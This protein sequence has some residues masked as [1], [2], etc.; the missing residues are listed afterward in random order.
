MCSETTLFAKPSAPKKRDPDVDMGGALI[1]LVAYGAQDVILTGSP[2]ITFFKQIYRRHTNFACESVKCTFSG[3]PSF[4]NKVTI[5]IPRNG[6]LLSKTYIRVA[7]SA[8]S[9]GIT[10]AKWA[11]VKNPG[12]A[13]I[14][15]AELVIGGQRID[16]QTGDWN[17]V[18]YE[19]SHP[20]GQ[21]RG[22]NKLIGNGLDQTTLATEH[23]A[24]VMYIPLNFF[25]CRHMGLALPLV[26]LQY[27]DVEMNITFE[28]LDNLIITSG[29]IQPSELGV[30]MTDG[31]VYADYV[32]LDTDERR[33]FAQASH[34][35]LI[36]AL[37]FTGQEHVRDRTN[38]IMLNFNHPVK[39][40]VWFVRSGAYTGNFTYLWY[41][42][43]DIDAMLNIATKRLALALA[44]YDGSGN[45][46]LN[47][48]SLI[49]SVGLPP[50]L[51]DIFDRIQA[52]SLSV[53]PTLENVT[54]LGETI[55]LVTAST[56]V[57]S[58]LASVSSRPLTGHGSAAYDVVVKMPHNFGLYLDGSVNPIE[59][60]TVMLNGHELFGAR[61]AAYFNYIKPLQHHTNTPS[62][63]V[64]VFSFALHPEEIQP[65][66]TLNFSRIDSAV[67]KLSLDARG[68]QFD[69]A[70]ISVYATSY[71]ELRIT[72]GMAGLAWSN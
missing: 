72:S 17:H 52:V 61:D 11:W 10:D 31:S 56:P 23:G 35:Y 49:A 54:V 71:N 8:G 37:Q 19:L 12:H 64:N 18:W 43:S 53:T 28:T 6:D 55:S 26:A 51:A 21:E 57:E 24:Y 36:E 42:P 47:N 14:K 63:G 29:P 67:L 2:Q 38:M 22:Y 66:G 13:I 41:H 27:H 9:V 20:V 62:D 39:E 3:A 5:K 16:L 58:L 65:S 25:Y 59:E 15:S 69:S 4:G 46:I 33:R 50:A 32:F 44:R 1:Q 68:V 7:V 30:S 40:M 48:G 70:S 60:A 45:L 34:N